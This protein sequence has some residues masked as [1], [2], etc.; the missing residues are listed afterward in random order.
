MTSD[1]PKSAKPGLSRPLVGVLVAIAVT[2][3]M[4][5]TGLSAFSALPLLPLMALFWYLERLPRQSVGFRWGRWSDYGLAALYPIVVIGLLVLI[6][7]A[8]GAIDVSHIDGRRVALNLFRVAAATFLVAIL[9]EEGFFRGWLWASLR[10]TGQTETRTLLW[11]S[12]A[13]ALWHV[14]AVTL[15]TGFEPPAAQ[16]PIFLVNAAVIGVVWGLLRAISGSVIVSSLSH[17]VWNGMAYVLFG[18]GTRVGALGIKNTAILGP[19]VGI[20]GLTLNVL[21]AAILWRLWLWR[22]A[23]QA[24]IP[25]RSA[26]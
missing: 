9:T 2:T 26:S 12:L 5:A 7:A 17:G 20:L 14:S 13:F 4:D 1:E 11:T 25:A 24:R 6:S 22:A 10:K 18:F 21:F 19:E 8:L 23:A 3:T 15:K 16:V